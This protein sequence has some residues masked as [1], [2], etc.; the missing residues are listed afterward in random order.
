MQW[1][2]EQ[3]G[4]EREW[5]L[6]VGSVGSG[7]LCQSL[8]C[9]SVYTFYLPQRG[10]TTRV[11]TLYIIDNGQ[12]CKVIFAHSHAHLVSYGQ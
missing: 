11:T 10:V 6:E 4:S 1:T 2:Q 5:R 7:L 9:Q 3:A 8:Q 12:Q